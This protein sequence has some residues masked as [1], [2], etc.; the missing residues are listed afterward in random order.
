MVLLQTTSS[1]LSIARRRYVFRSQTILVQS[2]KNMWI[3]P[4]QY[5]QTV[6]TYFYKRRVYAMELMKP[7]ARTEIPVGKDWVYE[8]KYDGFRCLLLWTSDDV[9]LKSR[10]QN[11]LTNKFPEIIRF[12]KQKQ[13][14][15]ESLLPVIL[16]GELVV[17]NNEFQANFSWMQTRG[18]L[19]NETS[20]HQAATT[21]PSTFLSFD[22]LQL[23]GVD[24]GEMS[25][26]E[27]KKTL[28][29]FISH[30]REERRSLNRIEYVDT[31][32]CPDDIQF[33]LFNHKGEG[34]IAKR[35]KSVYQPGTKHHDWFKIKNWRTLYGFLTAY[36]HDNDYF[37][38]SIFKNGM[39]TK[40]GTCKHGTSTHVLQTMKDF[41]MEKGSKREHL[42]TLPPAICTTIQSLDFHNGELREPQFKDIAIPLSPKACTYEKMQLDMAMLPKNVDITNTDKVFWPDVPVTKGELLVYM[43]EISPYMLPFLKNRLLTMIRCPDGVTKESFYQKHLP[44]YAPSYVKGVQFEEETFICCD[45]L[46]ALLWLANHGAVEYHIPFQTIHHDDPVE[47]V[48][49]LDP[50]HRDQFDLAIEAARLIKQL[51]DDLQLTSFVKTSGNKGLQV[52]IPLPERQMTYDET[53]LFTKAIAKTIEQAYPQFFTTERFKEKRKGRLYIDYVQHGKHKTIVA[54]YSPRKTAEASIATPL[55][56]EEVK[57]GLRPEQ[58]TLPDMLDR[59]QTNGCPFNTYFEAG[60]HQHIV[61]LKKLIT[62]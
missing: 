16:D 12:C 29:T 51:L 3:T 49:D 55:Y 23:Q 22:L 40:I 10:N 45:R 5:K 25:Y 20:I 62:P 59:V 24:V 38:V 61:P 37:T 57:E 6:E 44:S 41:F 4:T 21:R 27:R 50:P 52:Y 15:V 47:I 56:W 13:P 36:N 53:A 30:L 26:M 17:L 11:D 46:G 31:F 32:A 48:F 2:L 8:V 34:I 58:F 19:S 39:T 9:Q 1:D 28:H 7:I 14:F 33:L 60:K 42:Y 18:R 35:K 54:P 43:R